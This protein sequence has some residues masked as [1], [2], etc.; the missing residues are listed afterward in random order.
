VIA[1]RALIRLSRVTRGEKGLVYLPLSQS[2]AGFIRDSLL[3]QIATRRG[4]KVAAHLRG[5]EF[6]SFYEASPWFFRRWMGATLRRITSIAVMGQSLRSIFEGIV[7]SGR[8]VVVPNGTPDPA[9]DGAVRDDTTVLFLS[10]LRRRKG[11]VEAVEAARLVTREH[12]RARFLFVGACEDE[13]LAR[14]L[15]ERTAAANGRIQCKDPV[16]GSDKDRLLSSVGILLFPPTEPEGHPRV[17]L[18]ALAA[19][20]PVVTTD[21]GAIA[22]TTVDGQT[23]FVLPDSDP[24][25]LADRILLLLHDA[26]LRRRMG[27]AARARYLEHFTQ[28]QADRILAEWLSAAFEEHTEASQ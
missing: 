25:A 18:E 3:V 9:V 5:S 11:I 20:T 28:P 21:R 1:T 6:R 2:T 14:D 22:E 4:W 19:G 23:G 10:N 16:V 7:P 24:T 13:S 27:H 12:D 15:R 17:V 8:T 26:D